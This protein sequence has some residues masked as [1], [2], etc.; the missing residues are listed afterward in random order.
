MKDLQRRSCLW[1]GLIFAGIP[2]VL[3]VPAFALFT[4]CPPEY[5]SEIMV[6]ILVVFGGSEVVA[7]WQF[8]RI[9]RHKLDWL[10]GGALVGLLLATVVLVG[11]AWGFIAP[12]FARR[13]GF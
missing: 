8:S 2:A 7:G 5:G 1:R 9:L 3:F 10:S 12:I 6:A 11:I 4:I 13:A